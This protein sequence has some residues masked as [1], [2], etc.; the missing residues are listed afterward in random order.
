MALAL[1]KLEIGS[2]GCGEA[3]KFAA[4]TT[5]L[6][7]VIEYNGLRYAGSQMQSEVATVQSE[8]QNALLA[9]TGEEIRVSLAGRTDAGVH[10]YGQ[11]ASFM[12]SS[13]MPLHAFVSG[14]NHFLPA[15][16]SVKSARTV[17]ESFDPRRH[18]FKREYEYFILN[19]NTRSALW[20]GRA[21]QVAGNVDV[22]AMNTA[23]KLLLGEHD[24]A[25]FTSALD[26]L[27][28]STVRRMYE[29]RVDRNGNI[30]IVKLVAS[31][32][33]AH[34]VRNTV[35]ALIMVGQGKMTQ[36]AFQ[37]IIRIREFGLAGPSVPACGLYL[38]KVYYGDS[39]EEGF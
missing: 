9:L 18:A 2:V 22:S 34:Q 19:S 24:F 38:N 25:S 8:L 36:D 33:L 14:L 12:T 7:L 17:E 13:T 21:Y 23:C 20:S 39:L 6:A 16:I 32:F 37:G 29:A 1:S 3:E 11:V 4:P 5:R 15:D 10:A 31:A 30:I 26:N 27:G 35:G 28:K